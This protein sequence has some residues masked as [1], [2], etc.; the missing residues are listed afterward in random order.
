VSAP[1]T[2][3]AVWCQHQPSAA[4]VAKLA[5]T[6][7]LRSTAGAGPQHIWLPAVPTWKV[8]PAT[9]MHMSTENSSALSRVAVA[10]HIIDLAGSDDEIPTLTADSSLQSQGLD[11]LKVMSLVF[12]IEEHYDIVL[13]EG[14]ADDLRT[15]DDLA[16]L[17]VRCIEEQS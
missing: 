16:A 12:K 7:A 5:V 4:G 9:L 6:E 2:P 15:V 14:D 3:M 1:L 11:S 8:A 13:D 10:Q 17:V